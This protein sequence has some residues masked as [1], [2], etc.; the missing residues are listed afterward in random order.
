MKLAFKEP[1]A[2]RY[3]YVNSKTN[4]VHLLMPIMSGTDIGLDNTCKSVYS[5]QEF[6]GFLGANK[7]STASGIL[8]EYKKA[9]EFDLKYLSDSK[10]KVLKEGRLLQINTYLSLLAD[11]Q[12]EKQITA[13]LMQGFPTYPAPLESLMQ[14]KEANLYS[15]ILRPKTQDIYLRMTAIPPV[16][17]A[18]HDRLVNGQTVSKESLLYETL[19]NSYKGLVFNSKSTEQL[20]ARVLSKLAGS[21]V[22]FEQI[23]AKL[24]QEVDDYLGIKESFTQTQDTRYASSVLM[25][26]AYL[27]KELAISAENAATHEGYVKALLEYCAP[28]LCG[29]SCY[30]V[31]ATNVNKLG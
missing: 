20:I 18:N 30:M 4:I 28:N 31:V 24:T 14:A 22:D 11:V 15:V 2:P 10:E 1:V 23:R 16:F 12:K 6:F 5:L 9:L 29:D 19:S 26:Q 25:N 27:D 21:S 8:L 17:S 3:I 13:P 7:Q